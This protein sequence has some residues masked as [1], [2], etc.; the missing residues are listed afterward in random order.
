M[1]TVDQ[2]LRGAVEKLAQKYDSFYLYDERS[3][4]EQARLLRE[5][6]PQVDF[7]YSVKCNPHP[8]V[9]DCLFRQGFGADAASLGEVLL[10]RRL[11]L[12]R[13]RIYYSAPGKT[14]EDIRGAMTESVLIADSLG[15]L[16]ELQAAAEELGERV[17]VGIRV[18]P[19]FTFSGEEGLPSKFG[20]DETAA[21]ELAGS[22]AYPNLRFTGIHVHLK[23]QELD[24]GSLSRYYGKML[25]LAENFRAAWGGLAYVNLGSGMGIPYSPEDNPLD[26]KR[27]G[28]ALEEALRPFRARYPDTRV[29]IETGRLVTCRSGYYVTKVLDRK[30]SRGKTYLLLKNTLNGFL[31]PSLARLVERY[32]PRGELLGTEPLFTGRDAFGILTLG[33]KEP[34]ERVT[35][36]GNLCTA[37][38]VVA[39]DISLP[40]LERGD[41]VI[42][43]NAGSYGTVLSPMQFS[44]Q[45]KPAECF[46]SAEQRQPAAAPCTLRP[47]RPDY[48]GALARLF[49]KRV[50]E[51]LR[52]GIP[53]PYTEE[54]GRAFIRGVLEAEPGSVYAWAIFAG[55]ELCGSV[56][57]TR[58]GN[59]HR[60][61]GELGY[62]LG[63]PFWGRGIATAAVREAC[64]NLFRDTD[65]LRIFAE[66]FAYNTASCRVLEKSG[67]VLEG[68]LR[69]NAVKNGKVLDMKLYSLVKKP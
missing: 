26:L 8:R 68:T 18:N 33:E 34:E 46:L 64:C 59:I 53:Y 40:R 3:I 47:W 12:P 6:F 2:V 13:E 28:A 24:A 66:P 16:R 57:V 41:L 10:A 54:D 63:E 1:R 5:H 25:R 7:L 65:L 17:E 4:L 56:T 30:V 48:A 58:Q 23:S 55:E 29:I 9:L 51:N 60:Q 37:A 15:E 14:P 69:Q 49:S 32:A 45:E 35:L 39:E 67:F 27:L 19:D 20:M 43:T 44:G 22:R 42:L 62:F 61:T 11:G 36:A 50:L 31:R 21:L 52:D 38:D